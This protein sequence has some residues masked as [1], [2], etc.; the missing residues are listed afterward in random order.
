VN[1]FRYGAQYQDSESGLY[2]LRSRY[3]DPSTAQ[4]LS[5]DPLM[6]ATVSPYAY[7]FG[8]PLNGM[9]PSGL[10][11][12]SNVACDAGSVVGA[13]GSVVEGVGAGIATLYKHTTISFAGCFVVCASLSF[14]D[15]YFT[16]SGGCCGMIGR[17]PGVGW[18]NLA[19][20][21]REPESICA[22]GA[23]IVGIGGCLG[24]THVPTSSRDIQFNP[25]DW[26]IDTFPGV[27]AC[28]GYMKSGDP[29]PAPLFPH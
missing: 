7:T 5:P 20:D 6:A 16:P 24:L 27:G 25:C 14:Q 19:P 18:A 22:G 2:Y 26:E 23:Y 21:Q 10:C 28:G 9:D 1:P 4:F 3:Y 12:W 17:G 15:G 29:I 11:D 13:V 8:N